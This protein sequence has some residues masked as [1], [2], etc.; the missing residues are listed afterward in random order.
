MVRGGRWLYDSRGGSEEG[1]V[2]L[3]RLRR[4]P[5]AMLKRSICC[6]T[7]E[8]PTQGPPG[9]KGPPGEDFYVDV[10]GAQGPPGADSTVP[11]P[12]GPPGPPGD[13]TLVAGPAGPAGPPGEDVA[14]DGTT[15]VLGAVQTARIAETVTV[16]AA[17]AAAEVTVDY[18][19]SAV[20]F[21]S[22]TYAAPFAVDIVN[23]PAVDSA[24]RLH[25]V[26]LLYRTSAA[27]VYAN[28][29]H[30]SATAG[31]PFTPTELRFSMPPAAV[32]VNTGGD[33]GGYI[34][35]QIILHYADS[36]LNAL[37]SISAFV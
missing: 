34:L 10:E 14:A 29:V 20:H 21:L 2:T 11:G 5:P 33:D 23:L 27:G 24:A 8:G 28:L 18:G 25:V 7:Y 30:A 12:P 37:A 31:A 16:N 6:V 3:Y 1:Q 17:A 35:Q 36:G 19:A 13:I 32:A 22:A 26:S 4:R 15:T 9:P